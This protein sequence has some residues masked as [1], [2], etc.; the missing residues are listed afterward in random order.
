M[1]QELHRR[2]FD[3][4]WRWAG[5]FRTTD[6]NIGVPWPQ[7]AVDVKNLCDDTAVQMQNGVYSRDEIAVR[8]HYRLVVTHPFPNGNGRHARLAADILVRRQGGVAFPWGSSSLGSDGVARREYLASL[9]E[10]DGGNL[11]RLIRFA[12]SRS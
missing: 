7:I 8:F 11:E 3:R 12:R 9:K 6:T 1:L 10:A 2:M 5:K 4:T